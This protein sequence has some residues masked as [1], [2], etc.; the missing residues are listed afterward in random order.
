MGWVRYGREGGV[1]GVA[2][3]AAAFR[4]G[5]TGM[6]FSGARRFGLLL[7]SARGRAV[8]SVF[9]VVGVLAG[10]L[11]GVAPAS[12]GRLNSVRAARL[13]LAAEHFRDCGRFKALHVKIKVY[14]A[15]CTLAR[16]IVKAYLQG[17]GV[18]PVIKSVKGF[19]AWSC[20][21]GDRSGSCSKGKIARGVPAIFFFYLESPGSLGAARSSKLSLRP[22]MTWR[23]GADRAPFAVYRPRQT[24]GLKLSGLTFTASRCLVA[25]YGRP[26]SSKG[27]HVGLYEPGATRRCGQPGVGTTV[28]RVVIN[29]VK[30]PILVQCT[31]WPK[32]TVK[33]GESN[34]NFLV[35]VPEH[36]G[37]HYTIQL[38]SSHV[39]LSDFLKVARSFTRVPKS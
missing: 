10:V 3:G 26:G 24:L 12:V 14:R 28:R 8:L 37:L 30:V 31:T 39:L 6:T 7:R 22:A 13:S 18:G 9:A 35:F 19:P 25:S 20:S 11:P 32:C 38:Q 2:K 33:D 1:I 23:K 17:E 21:T 5:V 4:I 34:G 36:G 27:P 15:S 29:G 16:R